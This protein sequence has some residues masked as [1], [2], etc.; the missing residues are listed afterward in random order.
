MRLLT[1]FALLS[2]MATLPVHAQDAPCVDQLPCQL[3]GRSYHV[4]L[5]DDWD[6]VTPMPVMLHFHG[7][8]RQGTLIVKHGRISGA[9]R[10]R[11]VLLLAPNGINK[12]WD[13]WGPGSRDTDFAAAVIEDAARRYPIDRSQIFVS[14]YSYGSA[15][16]WRY[17]CENGA[18]LRALLAV[19]GTLNQNEECDTAPAEVRHVHGL[20]DTVL[21]YPFGPDGD[22]L[23]P[24][25]LW[26]RE[27]GCAAPTATD[28]YSTTDKDHFSR[29]IWADCQ[30]GKVVFDQHPR[31]HFIPRGWFA[32]QL[33]ELLEAGS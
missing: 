32:K 27:L 21:D 30:D 20:R 5:P 14:G 24:T 22:E 10:T 4:K 18:E 17:A 7:W 28:S 19:A 8:A 2:C 29:T 6:G 26:R 1:L 9:T 33:D 13:F 16:A 3:D 11:G 15:M 25:A 12:T 23:Y 31:G